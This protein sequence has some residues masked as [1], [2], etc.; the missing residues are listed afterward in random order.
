MNSTERKLTLIAT[1]TP[2]YHAEQYSK[3][4]PSQ[5]QTVLIRYIRPRRQVSLKTPS[6]PNHNTNHTT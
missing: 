4:I 1:L 6:I 3:L 2:S 5:P